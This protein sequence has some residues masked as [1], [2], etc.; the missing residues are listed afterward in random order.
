MHP[1]TVVILLAIVTMGWLASLFQAPTRL[2]RTA[3]EF[4]RHGRLSYALAF[5][6]A[7]QSEL[8]PAAWGVVP[9]PCGQA[10]STIGVRPS[11]FGDGRVGVALSL[12]PRGDSLD[13]TLHGPQ[14]FV[15]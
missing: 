6:T 13:M 5:L 12:T 9:P 2:S 4:A 14:P 8:R 7:P 10:L 15:P 1:R 3:A 11:R